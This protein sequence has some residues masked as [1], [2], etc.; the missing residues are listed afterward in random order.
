MFCDAKIQ[1]LCNMLT[2]WHAVKLTLPQA[3][4]VWWECVC[5]I[6]RE[7]CSRPGGGWCCFLESTHRRPSSPAVYS[8]PDTELPLQHSS[9]H[10]SCFRTPYMCLDPHNHHQAIFSSLK[11]AFQ[12]CYNLDLD[13]ISP[14]PLAF[15][16]W[17]STYVHIILLHAGSA[18][19]W[20][21]VKWIRLD[22]SFPHQVPSF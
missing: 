17:L 3:S 4:A 6:K 10:P 14:F 1:E 13:T 5:V 16:Q 18:L 19:K 8:S 11:A 22:H 20:L 21:T 2:C 7:R 9:C 15:H 12:L